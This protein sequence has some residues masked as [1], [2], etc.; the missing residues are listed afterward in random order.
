MI[1]LRPDQLHIA[2]SPARYRVLACGRRWG[3][4]TLA[5]LLGVEAAAKGA[6]VWWV[7][8]TYGQAIDAWHTAKNLGRDR[9]TEKLEAERIMRF[10]NGFFQ[11]KTAQ[12]PDNLRG[13]GLDLVIIDEAAYIAEYVWTHVLQPTLAD[14][15]GRGIFISTPCGKD[16]FWRAWQL[17]QDPEQKDWESWRFPTIANPLIAPAEEA[18]ARALLP[19]TVFRQEW[20]AEFIEGGG[21]VFI[22]IAEAIHTIKVPKAQPDRRYFMGV[23]W[24]RKEDFSAISIIDDLGYEVVLQ[25]WTEISWTQQRQRLRALARKWRCQRILAEANS[26]GDVNIEE[27]RKLGLPVTAFSMTGF[28]KNPLIEALAVAIENH[29]FHLS[30]NDIANQELEAF[31]LAYTQ[32]GRLRYAAPAGMHDDTVIARAL[33]H[34][35]RTGAM[36]I[37]TGILYA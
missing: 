21:Q 36:G 33:A 30:N 32:G 34:H 8:P 23:D 35:A 31:T 18:Q 4:T 37:T 28:S 16:W 2:Q 27:L 9:W 7:A 24:G 26:V 25:R 10:E 11:I 12:D 17:G 3:K 19:A 14:R 13:I 29:E 5:L 22:G 20:L 6:N 15:Q 1:T